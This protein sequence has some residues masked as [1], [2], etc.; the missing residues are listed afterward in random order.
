M[1]QR[2]F[3][4]RPIK[5]AIVPEFYLRDSSKELIYKYEYYVHLLTESAWHVPVLHG[6]LPRVPASGAEPVECGRYGLFMMMLFRPHR[7]VRD[8]IGCAL[9]TGDFTGSEDDAWMLITNEFHR[10]RKDDVDTI[11]ARYYRVHT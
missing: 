5:S 8:L 1:R 6:K 10:W 9:G 11:A 4:P 3:N 2:S 7:Y